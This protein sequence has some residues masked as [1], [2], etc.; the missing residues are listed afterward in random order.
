MTLNLTAILQVLWGANY[1]LL[2]FTY[3]VFA[4]YTSIYTDGVGGAKERFLSNFLEYF[5]ECF[6][7]HLEFQS[8]FFTGQ[9][10]PGVTF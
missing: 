5:L 3:D 6:T 9:F 8:N 1:I 10:L 7:E 2:Q 4:Q